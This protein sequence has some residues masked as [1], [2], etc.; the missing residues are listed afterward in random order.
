[1]GVGLGVERKPRELFADPKSSNGQH[2]R[3]SAGEEAEQ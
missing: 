3:T 1:M 2:R